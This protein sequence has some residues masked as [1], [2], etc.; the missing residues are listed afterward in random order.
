MAGAYPGEGVTAYATFPLRTHG[1]AEIQRPRETRVGWV[2]LPVQH[3]AGQGAGD[4]VQ[5]LNP[6]DDQPAQL[7]ET[8]AC[9]LAMTS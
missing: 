3:H 6:E 8:G 4:P 7:I 9:T 2:Q 1:A 5:D